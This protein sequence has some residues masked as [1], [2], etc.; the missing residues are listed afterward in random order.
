MRYIEGTKDKIGKW[1][2]CKE[3]HVTK[4]LC[5]GITQINQHTYNMQCIEEVVEH[6]G[7]C[8][9]SIISFTSSPIPMS[10][11]MARSSTIPPI[12]STSTLVERQMT[13]L[14]ML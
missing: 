6:Y 9:K 5:F 3:N 11:D 10:N 2:G 13:K 1:G 7:R 8:K 4:W 14:E 12:T